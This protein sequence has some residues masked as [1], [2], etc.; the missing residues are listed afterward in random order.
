MSS[1]DAVFWDVVGS[2]GV[3]S[4]NSSRFPVVLGPWVIVGKWGTFSL[5]KLV[6]SWEDESVLSTNLVHWLRTGDGG[7]SDL[8]VRSDTTVTC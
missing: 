4:I 1:R 6:V 8:F 2:S 7:F 5:D 3:I